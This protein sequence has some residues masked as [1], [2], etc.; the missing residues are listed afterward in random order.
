VIFKI[1]DFYESASPRPQIL[2]DIL[3]SWVTT[4]VNGDHS[5]VKIGA[6]PI[7]LLIASA[8]VSLTPAVCIL[9]PVAN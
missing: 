8:C 1:K 2:E 5:V 3:N 6:F 9:L 4:G 7:C